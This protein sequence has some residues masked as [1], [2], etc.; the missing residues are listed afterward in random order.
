MD[1]NLPNV[2]LGT[3]SSQIGGTR[4]CGLLHD[5]ESLKSGVCSYY[6][7]KE[8]IQTH[9]L[10][11]LAIMINNLLAN[12]L[13]KEEGPLF[14][15]MIVSQDYCKACSHVNAMSKTTPNGLLS[16]A[17]LYHHQCMNLLAA[18]QM[19]PA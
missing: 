18:V 2:H 16:R 1:G 7:R 8:L 19:P 6:P 12:G 15:C 17:V 4:D 13:V 3:S 10:H 9:F 5:T 11:I 14:F